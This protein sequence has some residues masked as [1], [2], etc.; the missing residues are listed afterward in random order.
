[1]I[2]RKPYKGSRPLTLGETQEVSSPSAIMTSDSNERLVFHHGHDMLASAASE[3]PR[4][5]D[6]G[7]GSQVHQRVVT[8]L[9]SGNPR[10][11]AP[12]VIAATSHAAASLHTTVCSPPAS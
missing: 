12:A 8:L 6:V 11:R 4:S 1:M 10:A 3:P 2:F 7:P 5:I 9:R